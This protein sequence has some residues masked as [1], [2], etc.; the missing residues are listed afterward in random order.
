[1][2]YYKL[3]TPEQQ[4]GEF[5]KGGICC[6]DSIMNPYFRIEKLCCR[7]VGLPVIIGFIAISIILAIVG[8]LVPELNPYFGLIMA[9]N[10]WIIQ[11]IEYIKKNQWTF[12]AYLIIQKLLLCTQRYQ[13][14]VKAWIVSVR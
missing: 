10:S 6:G 13:L 7:I 3:W 5:N 11:K 14:A 12:S 2:G 1:M 8:I 4:I 9:G